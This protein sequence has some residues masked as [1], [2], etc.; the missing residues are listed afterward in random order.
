MLWFRVPPKIFFRPGCL[1]VALKDLAGKKRALIV[2]DQ[3]LMEMGYAD[4]VT[5]ILDT[6]NVHHQLF[7]HVEPDPTIACI[8]EGLREAHSFK[9]DVII[10]LGGGSPMVSSSCFSCNR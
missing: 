10:A 3:P 8:E 7:Y 4:K 9:P 5:K 1:E 6:I 2:T